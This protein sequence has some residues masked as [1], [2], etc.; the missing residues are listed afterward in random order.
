MFKFVKKFLAVA[1][2]ALVAVVAVSCD[3]TKTDEKITITIDGL[4]DSYEFNTGDEFSK[5]ILLNG[6]IV[7]GS[8]EKDYSDYLVVTGLERF[9]VVD[10][11]LTESGSGNVKIEVIVDGTV[12]ASKIISITVKYVA[13]VTDDI[14]INGD[15]ATGSVDP[16]TKGEFNGGTGTMEVVNEEL[17]LTVTSL[18]WA[19][20]GEAAPRVESNIFTLEDG[21]F[22]EVSFDIRGNVPTSVQV[23]IGE[24]L[25]DNPWFNELFTK[26]FAVSTEMTTITYRF[27]AKGD[28]GYDLTKLQLLFG[29]GTHT[30]FDSAATDVYMDNISITEVSSLGEDTEAPVITASDIT[31]YVG[32]D[33]VID[34]TVKDNQ[35]EAPVVTNDADTVIPQENGKYTQEGTYTVTITAKDAAG[36][37]ASKTITVTVKAKV[38]GN[39]NLISNGDF[40]SEKFDSNWTF[41]SQTWC[42]IEQKVVNGELVL[43]LKGDT[44]ANYDKQVKVEHLPI[45]KGKKY[46]ISVVLTSS[47][48]RK[49][50]VLV[51][52]DVSYTLHYDK[53]ESITAG[54]D[55]TIEDTF[56]AIDTTANVFVG[57]MLGKIGEDTYSAD[58]TVTVKSISL[59][60]VDSE[61]PDQPIEEPTYADE[62]NLFGN[63]T[64]VVF[65]D[66]GTC[67]ANPNKMYVWH[68]QDASWGCGPVVNATYSIV[69]GVLVLNSTQTAD[70]MWFATQVF[71]TTLLFKK[72][73]TYELTLN[74]KSNVAGNV[75]ICGKVVTLSVGDNEVKVTLEV[76]AEA[77]VTYSMQLGVDGKGAL[78]GEIT[79]EMANFAITEKSGEE[80]VDP[81]DP[82]DPVEEGKIKVLAN[83]AS[84]TR[85][86]GAG[87]WI[88]V[89]MASIEMTEANHTTATI[90]ATVDP[91]DPAGNKVG[92]NVV[93]ATLSDHNF[94]EGYVRAYVALQGAPVSGYK[95]TIELTIVSNGKTFKGT[96]NFDG[97]SYVD[98]DA[99][100]VEPVEPTEGGEIKILAEGTRPTK[101][102]GAGCEIWFEMA[103]IGMVVEN[104]TQGKVEAGL[105][106]K[107]PQGEP[108]GWAINQAFISDQN[109]GTGYARVYVVLSGAPVSGY[110]TTITLKITLGDKY[111]TAEVSF[112]GP[113][114]ADPNAEPVE[115]VEPTEGG[116]IKILAEGTRP[117]KFTGAGCEIWFE[118]ASIEM[119]VENHTQGKV[120]ATVEA[121]DPAG[122]AVNFTV[123]Q[124]FISDQNFGTGYARVYVVLS[125]AP[126]EG[127]KT[128]ITLKITLGDKY[129]T[130]TVN[131][132]GANYVAE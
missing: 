75:T 30:G 90:E 28:A 37:E 15:F 38:V 129:Y 59:K 17:K 48:D 109:F 29:F 66:E 58:H 76:A 106:V 54:A 41:W 70:H 71:Y 33:V 46:S 114:Y 18:G 24:L 21:K 117:T 5:D 96:V 47:I 4:K 53:V 72:A 78:A 112:D 27:A 22:Y 120:E 93:S 125:G 130:A 132:D 104:H 91:R 67:K 50:E 19:N 122:E 116:E 99:E 94:A 7:K 123:N 98:P 127:Y 51:Q 36:N 110:K 42:T 11:K 43:T 80:P 26:T 105:D 69:D 87:A 68:V 63:Y 31:A 79:L 82:V 49:V 102:T 124:A 111:Y 12:V 40:A 3:K 128:T 103:S 64:E 8:D 62:N 44:S 119:V 77:A 83:G 126:V 20:G 2:V 52:N 118:M 121:T 55:T 45:V 34:A 85:F 115:P 60:L 88:W 25:S 89:D 81:V 108:V 92:W 56:T 13:P 14:I 9:K 6:I 97:T 39:V 86:E 100:P 95:T 101:F 10:G 74:V 65:G 113:D 23:Q 73:G 107:G 61:T 16:F 131:F 57:L 32:E 1:L 35:D 84:A